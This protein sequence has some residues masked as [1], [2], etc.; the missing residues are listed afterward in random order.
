MLRWIAVDVD[1][2][3]HDVWITIAAYTEFEEC[4]K[5]FIIIHLLELEI[6]WWRDDGAWAHG[7]L[8]WRIVEFPANHSKHQHLARTQTK[9]QMTEQTLLLFAAKP[10]LLWRRSQRSE[11]PCVRWVIYVSGQVHMAWEKIHRDELKTPHDGLVGSRRALL[12][13]CH[14]SSSEWMWRIEGDTRNPAANDIGHTRK[15]WNDENHTDTQAATSIVILLLVL[16]FILRTIND[17]RILYGRKKTQEIMWKQLK[18]LRSR[19]NML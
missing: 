8:E 18:A 7:P 17:K 9:L 10:I 3:M 16:S 19:W 4:P 11:M 5:L 2:K 1:I 14:R 13:H 6:H 12:L 15:L